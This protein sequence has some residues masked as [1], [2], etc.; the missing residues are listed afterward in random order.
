MAQTNL[1]SDA[2]DI[3]N[4]ATKTF[5]WTLQSGQYNNTYAF[6][7][8]GVSAG[9]NAV[10]SDVVDVSSYLSGRDNIL[11]K[12]NPPIPKMEEANLPPLT[13]QKKDVNTLVPLYTREKKSTS[14]ATNKSYIP[15]SF[16]P[17]VRKDTQSVKNIVF[18]GWSQ[19]GG[20]LTSNM[21]KDEW[22]QDPILHKGRNMVPV[23]MGE[24][25]MSTPTRTESPV[26]QMTESPQ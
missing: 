4:Q 13:V 21:I 11:S 1:K 7:T 26:P 8:V 3:Y 6:G 23:D 20:A 9:S 16:N 22:Q 10:R 24:R 25:S 19:R 18:T 14:S 15:Y 17:G 5:D 12:C 2:W